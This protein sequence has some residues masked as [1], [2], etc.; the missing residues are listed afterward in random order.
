MLT[1]IA[2]DPSASRLGAPIVGIDYDFDN[3]RCPIPVKTGRSAPAS[4]TLRPTFLFQSAINR[5]RTITIGIEGGDEPARVADT[6]K[7]I[8]FI[9]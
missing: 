2:P 4:T 5:I 9:D 7:R 6:L 8:V 1:S 3:T